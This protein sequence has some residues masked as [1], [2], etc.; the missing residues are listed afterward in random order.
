MELVNYESVFWFMLFTIVIRLVINF[1]IINKFYEETGCY[2]VSTIEIIK[3]SFFYVVFDIRFL[4]SIFYRSYLK[5][6]RGKIYNKVLFT[7]M[8]F[9]LFGLVLIDSYLVL[10]IFKM[11]D[12]FMNTEE[13]LIVILCC[14]NVIVYGYYYIEKN[15]KRIRI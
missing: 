15:N 6:K 13:F 9:L 2:I 10:T 1:R 4:K 3:Q 7:S 11:F 5:T 12:Y 8:I 14:Y